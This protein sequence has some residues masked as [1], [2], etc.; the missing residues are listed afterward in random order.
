[1]NNEINLT[2]RA[3]KEVE[4]TQSVE[5]GSYDDVAP[6]SATTADGIIIQDPYADIIE[7]FTFDD[8][9]QRTY[10]VG[11]YNWTTAQ[12][13]GTVITN[14][15]FPVALFNQPFIADKIKNFY[16]FRG[17]VEINIR[18]ACSRT[19]YGAIIAS[20]SPYANYYPLNSTTLATQPAVNTSIYRMSGQPHVIAQASSSDVVSITCPFINPQR[21]LSLRKYGG[22]EICSFSIAV[23]N[24]LTNTE[25]AVSSGQIFV[26]A[27]FVDPDRKS[28]V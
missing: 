16:G 14:I 3:T 17:G 13:A 8:V 23:L 28:V 18:I 15:A 10:N 22:S 5:L 9:L 4:P 25:N 12:T 20:I 24:P 7:R 26:T 1:M 11:V 21:F 19:L 2:D 6:T 27:R